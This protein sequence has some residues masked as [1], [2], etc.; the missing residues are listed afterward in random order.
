MY[1]FD[2]LAEQTDRLLLRVQKT[3]LHAPLISCMSENTGTALRHTALS[4][5]GK[6]HNISL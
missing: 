4:V 5:A 6:D 1:I 2:F 3:V